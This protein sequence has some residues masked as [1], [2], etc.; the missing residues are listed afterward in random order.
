MRIRIFSPFCSSEQ[1]AQ[2]YKNV[3]NCDPGWFVND[4][5]YTHVIIL[6]NAMPSISHITPNRVVGLAFEPRVWVGIS[7]EFIAYAQKHI[8]Q[9]F[10]GNTTGLPPPFIE[11][12][13]YMWHKWVSSPLPI[14]P[15]NG[16]SMMLSK[17][18]SLAGHQYRHILADE[19]LR[20]NLPV[21]IWGEWC[22][23]AQTKIWTA[24]SVER[25]V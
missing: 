23:S 5:S 7:S 10:M 11:H 4:D 2:N 3:Y 9:Y 20:E 24:T 1:A 8:G 6:N 21:D 12:Y 15:H 17:Q 13:S 22:S 16:I 14:Q 19:I 18:Q 25:R